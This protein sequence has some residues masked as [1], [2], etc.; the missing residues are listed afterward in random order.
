[1]LP[2]KQTGSRRIV[3]IILKDGL[4]VA[5]HTI[6]KC[7][8]TGRLMPRGENAPW[9]TTGRLIQPEQSSGSFPTEAF[10]Q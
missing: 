8:Y 6:Q 4:A 1:L 7:N 2:S 5:M 10:R 9:A 3:G